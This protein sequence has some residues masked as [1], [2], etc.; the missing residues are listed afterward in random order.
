MSL[1]SHN[2]RMD[3][4]PS[5]PFLYLDFAERISSSNYRLYSSHS[6]F[7]SKVL[8]ILWI[9]EGK[10]E[11]RVKLSLH[12]SF[13]REKGITVTFHFSLG[14]SETYLKLEELEISSMI[15]FVK[16]YLFLGVQYIKKSSIFYFL[17]F[18]SAT[19]TAPASPQS[20]KPT[21]SSRPAIPSQISDTFVAVVVT[22]VTPH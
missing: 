5:I 1:T 22:C 6:I 21:V 12:Q 19:A 16:K 13:S 17:H 18:R 11:M 9:L 20:A 10:G 4:Y 7:F 2:C 14:D 3:N 15:F 8:E